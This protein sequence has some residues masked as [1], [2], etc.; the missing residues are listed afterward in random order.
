LV[1]FIEFVFDV[2]VSVDLFVLSVVEEWGRVLIVFSF[3]G[4][5][6]PFFFDLLKK[7]S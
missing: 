4:D 2:G 3:W 5:F 6:Y 7:L 1:D